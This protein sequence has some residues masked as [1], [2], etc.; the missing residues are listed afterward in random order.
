MDSYELARSNVR[1][2][3]DRL[4]T[5]RIALERGNYPYAVRQAQECVELS[6]KACLRL[7]GI[8]PPKWHDVGPIIR[9]ERENFPEWFKEHV[10]RI[11]SISRSLRKERELA[12]YGDEESKIPPEELYTR[13]DAEKA[14]EDAGFVLEIARRLLREFA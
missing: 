3:E 11:V 8:E 7:V 10:E 2:A 1:Q 4:T 12:M 14:I 9:R 5:A 13:F 6:L